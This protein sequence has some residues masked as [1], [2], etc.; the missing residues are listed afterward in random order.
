MPL[1]YLMWFF[2]PFRCHCAHCDNTLGPEAR[3]ITPN[4]T[5][6]ADYM[7]QLPRAASPAEGRHVCVR[8]QSS[9]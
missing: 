9:C 3:K 7:Q 4:G 2:P 6:A 8:Y 1:V 5:A